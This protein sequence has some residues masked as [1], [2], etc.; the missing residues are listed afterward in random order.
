MHLMAGS[1]S[2]QI[3]NERFDLAD[4]WHAVDC[5][6]CGCCAYACPSHRPLVQHLRRAKGEIMAKR[7]AGAAKK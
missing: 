6:E 4:E 3:E 2:V 1:L 5:I 7:K